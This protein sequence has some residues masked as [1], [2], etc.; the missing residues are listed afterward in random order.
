MG[1]RHK[2]ECNT[3]GFHRTV[4]LTGIFSNHYGYFLRHRLVD[5]LKSG[6]G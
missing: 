5:T 6:K 2:A 4:R 3:Q 1:P